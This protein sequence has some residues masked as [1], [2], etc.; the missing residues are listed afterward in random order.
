MKTPIWTLAL[1]V[2]CLLAACG[3]DDAASPDTT[4]DSGTPDSGSGADGGTTDTTPEPDVETPDVGV[5]TADTAPEDVPDVADV[6]VPDV[7]DDADVADVSDATD[8]SSAPDVVIPEDT[9]PDVPELITCTDD[10]SVCALPYSC[11]AD[12]CRLPIER[13]TIV[14]GD[15]TFS[16]V[17]PEELTSIFSLLKTLAIDAKFILIDPFDGSD[18]AAVT[19]EYGS[20]DVERASDEPISV[21]WQYFVRDEIVFRPDTREGFEDPRAWISDPFTYDLTARVFITLGVGEPVGGELGF[22]A[23]QVRIRVVLDEDGL[24][25]NGRLEG[26]MTREEAESRILNDVETFRSFVGLLC[27]DTSF[28][29]DDGFWHLSDVLDCNGT[30]IDHDL[31][32]DTVN[33]SYFMQI[34]IGFVAASIV[35]L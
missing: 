29:P 8:G 19:A 27:S 24:G 10:P 3:G 32:G 4:A 16:V 12:A 6:T 34:D 17:Q 22:E 14:E 18:N 15:E 25:G 23:Q 35:A 31:D 20:A 30:P 11:I 26:Y 28:E 7:T 21:S 33:D 9:G 1:T 5:D 2:G 13:R